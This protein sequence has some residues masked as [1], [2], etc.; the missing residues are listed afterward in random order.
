MSEKEGFSTYAFCCCNPV[1][2]FAFRVL[3]SLSCLC[4]CGSFDELNVCVFISAG[5]SDSVC[6]RNMLTDV[7]VQ[8]LAGWNSGDVYPYVAP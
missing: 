3:P 6:V 8:Y 7:F 5:Y 1:V 2:A 4:V